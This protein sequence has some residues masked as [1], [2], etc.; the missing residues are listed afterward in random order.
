MDPK[1]VVAD[2][3][4]RLHQVYADWTSAGHDGLRRRYI[5][6]VLGRG[7]PA[8]AEALDL[9]CGTGRHATAYL[10]ERGLRVTGVDISPRSIEVAAGEVPGARFMVGDMASI[11]LPPRSF[12]LVTA[13]YSVIHVPMDEHGQ[14]LA[15][16]WSWLRPGGYMVA[17]MGGGERPGEGVEQAWLGV[18]PMF[19]SNWDVATSRRLV[20][21]AGFEEVEANLEVI[22]EDGRPVT[23]LWV[24]ARKGPAGHPDPSA[25]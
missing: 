15:R 13:F 20:A 22:D 10:V 19:W 1:R 8:S 24:V 16:I 25:G 11:D 6:K 5:D 7:L 3:Y 14:L 21:E 4:D 12:D 9:G 18:A 17:T 23:F 2:G